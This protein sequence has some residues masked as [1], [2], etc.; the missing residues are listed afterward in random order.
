[1]LKSVRRVLKGVADADVLL[2]AEYRILGESLVT[3]GGQGGRP[4][5]THPS[6]VGSQS[7]S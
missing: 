5:L 6:S 4:S 3:Q 2:D 7:M 1:M